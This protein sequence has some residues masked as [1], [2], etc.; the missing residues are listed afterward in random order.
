MSVETNVALAFGRTGLAV[1]F[2]AEAEL[3]VIRKAP[4]PKLADPVAAVHAAL[5][6]P[7]GSPTLRAAAAGRRSA[8]ILVCDIT[9]PV[10]NGLFLRPIVDELT[11]AGILLAGDHDPGGDRLHRPGDADELREIVGDPWIFARADRETICAQ[12]RRPRRLGRD[13]AR[14]PRFGLN[15][16]FVEAD[17]ALRPALPSRTSL[18]RYWA[19]AKSSPGVAHAEVIRTF[20]SAPSWKTRRQS[21][22][23]RR[24][25]AARRTASKWSR[26]VGEIFAFNTVIDSSAS[27]VFAAFGDIA[28]S[29]AAAVKYVEAWAA[30]VRPATLSHR[31][32]LL[33]PA[34]SL[35]RRTIRPS[36]AWSFRS[37]I[38]PGGTLIVASA[39]SKV[40][41]RRSSRV[42]AAAR[43][44]VRRLLAGDRAK[45]LADI[46][47]WQIEMLRAMRAG[48]VSYTTGLDADEQRLTRR[49][50]DRPVEDAVRA[51]IVLHGDPAVGLFPKGPTSS[52]LQPEP[53]A[54]PISSR[55]A[56][57][58]A[59][60]AAVSRAA[61]DKGP[62]QDSLDRGP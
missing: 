59:A 8:C 28:A 29:H 21:R 12:R 44:A 36:K 45:R 16:R 24:Q 6:Q 5:A 56:V 61:G 13:H 51:S 62:R 15:R 52:L 53:H 27:L 40:S 33:P 48:H 7:I 14:A 2:P 49:R 39:C 11:G 26:R 43:R 60:V 3:T 58:A 25:S 37:D 1:R 42:T 20:H 31:R 50:D 57:A 9:R 10:P 46:D 4:R 47:E 18:R 22:A 55:L 19:V 17:R 32:H 54:P 38:A 30:V 34:T 41:A 35:T 23:T